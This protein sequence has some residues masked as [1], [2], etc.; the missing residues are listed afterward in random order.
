M[1][2]LKLKKLSE[3]LFTELKSKELEEESHYKEIEKNLLKILDE[4]EEP[5]TYSV[6]IPSNL[7]Y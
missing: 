5:L 6:Q 1:Y 3:Q 7:S 2:Q 4:G